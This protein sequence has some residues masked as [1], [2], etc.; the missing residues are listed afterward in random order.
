MT[1][2]ELCAE[3]GRDPA[4][5]RRSYTMFDPNARASG[6]AI[7]YYESEDMFV[8]MVRQVVDL[9][10]T[11][12]SLYYPAVESQLPVFE[13]IATTVL[14][15]LRRNPCVARC[16]P[17]SRRTAGLVDDGLFKSE[18]VIASPQSA[19]IDAGRRQ[20][21]CS[22]CAPTTTSASPIT[23]SWSQAAHAALD[24]YGYGM[25]S[26]RFICGTQT[27]HNELEAA[28]SA[29]PRHRRHDPL[30]VVLRRQRRA[31]RDA[32]R[33]AGRVISDA[34]NHASIIDGIRL[35]K[36]QR[37]ALRQQRHGRAGAVP[38]RRRAARA[39]G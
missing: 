8:D 38:A 28:L 35:C 15:E 9:G 30:L 12:I 18:R 6:G 36:A 2:D 24:A 7:N 10:I 29:L 23:P 11:E 5:L 13:R 14:P 33:R 3:L 21:R 39:T 32:A 26:V 27:V 25:A 20:P 34:L 37:H 22:T 16:S 1:I 17:T 31:V 19:H 4:T